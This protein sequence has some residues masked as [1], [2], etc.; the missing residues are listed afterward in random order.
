MQ[1]AQRIRGCDRRVEGRVSRQG[2][3][4]SHLE[5]KQPLRRGVGATAKPPQCTLWERESSLKSKHPDASAQG[6]SLAYS[7]ATGR[8]AFRSPPCVSKAAAH[9]L[10]T[11]LS[12]VTFRPNGHNRRQAHLNYSFFTIHYSLFTERSVSPV[13]CPVPCLEMAVFLV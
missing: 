5:G 3:L 13:P 11:C 2:R 4:E 12:S 7:Y 1:I 9:P 8:G 6:E 10:R